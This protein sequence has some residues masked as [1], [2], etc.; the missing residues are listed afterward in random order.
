M[1][2]FTILLNRLFRLKAGLTYSVGHSFNLIVEQ[3]LLDAE[4]V[5][6]SPTQIVRTASITFGNSGLKPA[7]NVEIAFNWK[8]IF[9]VW[10]GRSFEESTNAL[11]RYSM[12]LDSLAPGERFDIEIMAINAELP[13]LSAVR[14]EDCVGKL[15]ITSPQRVWPSWVIN[16]LVA[17]MVLGA[18]TA[19]YLTITGLQYLSK[20][21]VASPVLAS[22]RAPPLEHPPRLP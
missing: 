8:P 16:T 15:I 5:Q 6:I 14:S 7:K 22:K 19:L 3:P 9:N 21:S 11:G 18:G 4:G 12:K 17:L 1:V 20:P 13:L 2:L 10:P